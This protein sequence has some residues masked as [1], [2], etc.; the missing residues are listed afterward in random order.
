MNIP[1]MAMI[2]VSPE[3]ITARPEVCR[4]HLE[5]VLRAPAGRPLFAL[6]AH[7]EERVVDSDGESDQQDQRVR[8][9]RSSGNT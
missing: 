1:A 5:R 8:R 2:T 3:I 7:V 9:C 6:T 4:S